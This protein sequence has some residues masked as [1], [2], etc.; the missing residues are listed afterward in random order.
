MVAW[1]S[2]W[3]RDIIA[4]IMLAVFMELLLPNKSMQRYARLVV[5]LLILLTI[6]SPILRLLQG[7]FNS[8]LNDSIQLWENGAA[9]HEVKMPTLSDIQQDADRMNKK[10]QEEAAVLTEQ[11]L[12]KAM[13][14]A[15]IEQTKA[16][17]ANVDVVLKWVQKDKQEPIPYLNA[18]TV[19]F[20]SLEKQPDQA[21]SSNQVKEVDA[22]AVDINVEIDV[23]PIN[24]DQSQTGETGAQDDLTNKEIWGRVNPSLEE[25]IRSVLMDGWGMNGDIIVIRQPVSGSK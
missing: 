15:I 5:G 21:E 16:P 13:K 2:D 8:K 6:L 4:V 24:N 10:R 25:K 17:V 20:L 11:N 1:L 3:L 9:Q 12:E 14:S 19:T 23:E 22:V 18:V 7:D